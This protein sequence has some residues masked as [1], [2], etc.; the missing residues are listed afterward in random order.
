MKISLLKVMTSLISE[1]TLYINMLIETELFPH[2]AKAMQVRVWCSTCRGLGATKHYLGHG[3]YD[4][5]ECPPC[6]NRGYTYGTLEGI[7]VG[8]EQ[9]LKNT[10]YHANDYY[11]LDLKAKLNVLFHL[12]PNKIIPVLQSRVAELETIV[13]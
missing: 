2:L 5:D 3:D 7:V 8:L 13:G 11:S 12:A 1:L 4:E 9:D 6:N 10:N